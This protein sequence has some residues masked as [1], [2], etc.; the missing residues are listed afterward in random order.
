[1]AAGTPEWPTITTEGA[2]QK[3]ATNITAITVDR[4]KSNY[5]YFHTYVATGASAPI[6]GIKLK[7]PKLFKDA[8]QQSITASAAIDVYI[9]LV[10]T[11]S[12]TTET[13]IA[14][15]IQVNL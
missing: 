8:N 2:W 3:I 7:S 9:W 14:N 1:M 13:S 10:G 11:N 4:L 6:A 12:D 15:T 5:E